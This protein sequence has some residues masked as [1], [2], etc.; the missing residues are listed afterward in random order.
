MKRYLLSELSYLTGATLI[1]DPNHAI[2]GVENLETASPQEAAFLENPRYE[3]QLESSQAGVI[4]IHPT[5]KTL[6]GKNYLTTPNPSLAFQKIIEL[7]LQVPRSG[8]EGIHPT[9][10][11][12]PEATL[13][14]GVTIAPHAVIDRGVSIGARTTIGPGT[15][16]GAETRI[17]SDCFFYANVT[18]RENCEIG[19]R[20]II[21]PGG[22]IGSCGFGY[23]TDAKGKHTPLKQLGKVIIEDDV[24]IGANTTIDRARFKTT[25]IRRGT[26]IDNLVQIAHQ[27]ELGEDNLIVSQVGI[28]GSTKTGRNVVMG[29]Q[30]GVAGHITIADG[31]MLA[32]R[33]AV[34]KSLLEPGPYSGAPAAPIKEFNAQFVQLR[35]VGKFIQRLK[36]LEVKVSSLEKSE[37]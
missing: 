10:V 9:A 21:Q 4:L 33:A 27:V 11:I 36:D 6:P 22:V 3:K 16:I 7:F 13:G 37:D 15:F 18:I 35:M 29:G 17:G 26:K 20:V 34:S 2:T 5:V 31:V 30:V 28:A 23:F 1:G 8:F 12:H 32:A 25:R 19:N 14:E 24:E